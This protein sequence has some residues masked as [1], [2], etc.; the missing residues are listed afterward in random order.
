MRNDHPPCPPCDRASRASV[1]RAAVAA[2]ALLLGGAL[3][4]VAQQSPTTDASTAVQPEA[5]PAA[6]A[7][8][9]EFTVGAP[10]VQ[11]I[12]QGIASVDGPTIWRVREVGLDPNAQQETGAAA[13]TL[14][15]TGAALIRNDLTTRRVRLEPGQ[16][17]F[18]PAG[19]PFTRTAIGSDP[20]IVWV[21][22]VMPQVAAAAAGSG[23]TLFTSDPITDYPAGTF[24]VELQRSVL[25]PGEV[26]EIPPHTGPALLLVSSGRVQYSTVGAP[27][28]PLGAGSAMMIPGALTL[29]N[30]DTQPAAFAVAM[31][32]DG[33]DGSEGFAAAAQAAPQTAPS[34]AAPAAPTTAPHLVPTVI[35]PVTEPTPIPAPPAPVPVE[36]T[37]VPQQAQAAPSDGDTDGDGLSDAE[38]A[39]YG[40]DPLNKDYDA[41]GLLDGEE[42][43]VYGTDPL[44]NDTDGDGL[45]DG[46]EVYTYGTNPATS[47]SD[48]DGLTDSEEIFTYGTDPNAMDTDGDGVPD[49]E[50]V[51]IY[52]TDP[53]DPNSHP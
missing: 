48:G 8:A 39:A 37:P 26:T 40:S 15:R 25:L 23:T 3:P 31:L 49:G 45:L 47:D 32:G 21:I 13:F 20:S 12:A 34:G 51:Y 10:H 14:Q 42:V 16:A 19:D 46:E 7:A 50:E 29:R 17:S 2:A 4:A 9:P 53:L 30:G 44:N 35:P 33:V 36:P 11:S 6:P 38:E 22:E 18:Q 24:D 27:P 1:V 52:G 5:Q 28:A 43:Y 41:D